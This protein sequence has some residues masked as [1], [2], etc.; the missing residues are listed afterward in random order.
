MNKIIVIGFILLFCFSCKQ[1]EIIIPSNVIPFDLMVQ[2]LSDV[3]QSEV[4][5]LFLRNKN[6]VDMPKP[7][8]LY[9]SILNQHNITA[10]EFDN[11]FKFYSGH[12]E[13]MEKLYAAIIEE[14][15]KRQVQLGNTSIQPEEN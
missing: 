12:T 4:A 9:K 13:L 10:E 8:S 7:E 5:I 3:Q 1:E 6:A 2:V 14:L 11:S 15:T